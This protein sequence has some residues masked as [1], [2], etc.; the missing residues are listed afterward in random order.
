MKPEE[1]FEV[2]KHLDPQLIEWVKEKLETL[3]GF[4]E[5]KH[6]N[7]ELEESV[8]QLLTEPSTTKLFMWT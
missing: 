6:W 1:S 2:E 7:P 3:S 4:D 8:K 5:A